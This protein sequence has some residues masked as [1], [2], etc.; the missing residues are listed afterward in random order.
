MAQIIGLVLVPVAL[1]G[2][3]AL[4]TGR[5]GR[6]PRVGSFSLARA[7]TSIR[8]AQGQ[9]ATLVLAVVALAHST[10]DLSHDF[11][12]ASSLGS[13]AIVAALIVLIVGMVIAP[14]PF[15]TIVAL[16][17]TAVSVYSIGREHGLGDVIVLIVVVILLLWILGLVRG[18]VPGER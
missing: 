8:S 6:R 10:L 12:R 9:N 5:L 11:P 4:A 13:G 1:I 17:A 15:T 14:R 2:I 18:F 7:S 3:L 16:T